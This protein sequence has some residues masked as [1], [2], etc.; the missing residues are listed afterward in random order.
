LAETLKQWLHNQNEA[1]CKATFYRAPNMLPDIEDVAEFLQLVANNALAARETQLLAVQDWALTSIGH[2]APFA[3]DWVTVLRV[4]KEEL[5][6][7]LKQEYLPTETLNHWMRLDDLFSYALIEATQL[8][9]DMNR[10]AMLEHMD[11]LRRQLEHVEKTK[12]NF[13]A[14]AAHELKTPLTILEGYANMLRTET[15]P[16]SQLRIYVEG[17]GNGTRRLNEIIADIIDVSLIDMHQ[18]ELKY[19]QFYLEKVI[20]M[21]ADKVDK[22]FG[23]RRVDLVIMPLP[24]EERIYGDPEHLLKAFSKVL[25][26]GLK[27]TPDGGRV[28]VTSVLTRHAEATDEITGYVDVQISDTGIGIDPANFDL[29]FRKF[30]AVADASLHS[31]GKTKFKGGGPGLGLSIAKGI[32]EAHGGRIWVESPG[33][34][35]QTNPGSTF[36]LEIPRLVKMPKGWE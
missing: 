14:V 5:V 10:S 13:I 19:Q 18:V 21:A 2:D 30:T 6:K 15:T 36:H 24:V 9:S 25:L 1:L 20:L 26:N 31:S 32:V 34:D 4:L 12:A 17:L 7:A 23:Q 11:A 8:A 28:T 22:F 3:N 35:E 29:I 33:W 27:Y 16:D